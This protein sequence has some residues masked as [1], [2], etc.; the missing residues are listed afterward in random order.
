MANAGCPAAFFNSA[1][2]GKIMQE[3]D[4]LFLSTREALDAVS[5]AFSQY[6]TQF[7]MISNVWALVFGSDTYVVRDSKKPHFWAKTSNRSK[8]VAAG[9]DDLKQ[10]VVQRLKQSP[11]SLHM[12]AQICSQVFGAS[13]RAVLQ[14]STGKETGGVWIKTDMAD[15][16]CIQC[17]HCCRT[18]NY[19][20]GCSLEDFRRWRQLGRD[21]ILAWVGTVRRKGRLI[22]C[23]IW[24]EP[25]TNRY[26]AVCPWL[27]QVD[28]SGRTRCTIHEVRPSICRQYPG[29]RKHARMTGCQGV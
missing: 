18:L 7:N 27:K 16:K 29:T 9:E 28:Q 22:A 19:S 6:P 1:R 20:D 26:A 12:L 23:R 10:W 21:D 2:W 15:F 24:M 8:L 14:P 17:G 25:G 5:F 11:P 13:A 4:G 3:E